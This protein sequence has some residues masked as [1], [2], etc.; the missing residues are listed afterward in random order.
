MALV[1]KKII[2]GTVFTKDFNPL[3]CNNQIDFSRNGG[4]AVVISSSKHPLLDTVE[5]S[6]QNGFIKDCANAKSK[7][8]RCPAL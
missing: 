1:F 8:G 4:I 7:G 5:D 3:A 2:N 6:E